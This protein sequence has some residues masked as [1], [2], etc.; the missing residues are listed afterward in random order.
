MADNYTI[1]LLIYWDFKIIFDLGLPAF[2]KTLLISGK[3]LCS[4]DETLAFPLA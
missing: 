2:V 1:V 3:P 4:T